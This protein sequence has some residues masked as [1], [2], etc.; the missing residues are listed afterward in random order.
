[1][2]VPAMVEAE[3]K[4]SRLQKITESMGPHRMPLRPRGGSASSRDGRNAPEHRPQA[5]ITTK[6]AMTKAPRPVIPCPTSFDEIRF[7]SVKRSRMSSRAPSATAQPGWPESAPS[8]RLPLTVVL[9]VAA[10]GGAAGG[11]GGVIAG[12]DASRNACRR[13]EALGAWPCSSSDCGS[14]CCSW[15]WL[16]R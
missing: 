5:D 3:S 8:H 12:G 14:S 4:P 2:R 6:G 1:M 9:V 15:R 13:S 16:A 7:G 10:G 11:M